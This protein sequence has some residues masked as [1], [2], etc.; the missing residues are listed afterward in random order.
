[1][2]GSIILF[3]GVNFYNIMVIAEFWKLSPVQKEEYVTIPCNLGGIGFVFGS[4]L[5]WAGCTESWFGVFAEKTI[6]W[7]IGTL[8]VIGSICF[9]VGGALHT[10]IDNKLRPKFLVPDYIEVLCGYFLGSVVFAI[11]SYLMILEI[12]QEDEF[13]K[14]NDNYII[15]SGTT[16]HE[17]GN[18]H[19]NRT[20]NAKLTTHPQALVY[21]E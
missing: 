18:V 16:Y 20:D 17:G 10:P 1:M 19:A 5:L 15:N 2:S 8:N 13:V 21:V 9:L 4:Y 11:S 3:C 7:W 6:T 14:S 12:A